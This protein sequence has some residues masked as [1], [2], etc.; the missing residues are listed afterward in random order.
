MGDVIGNTKISMKI[1][2]NGISAT[3]LKLGLGKVLAPAD[4]LVVRIE[5]DTA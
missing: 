4:N 3:T 2:G 1:V 5:T